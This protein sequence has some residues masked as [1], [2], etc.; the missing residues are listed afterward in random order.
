MPPI[1]PIQFSALKTLNP[2]HDEVEHGKHHDRQADVRQVE[3]GA[4]LGLLRLMSLVASEPRWAGERPGPCAT[5]AGP[6]QSL[7]RSM[8]PRRAGT[9][10]MAA[11]GG[12]PGRPSPGCWPGKER[13]TCRAL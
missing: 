7:T 13:S 11:S 10:D 6:R 4:L 1:R 5:H 9:P 2:L 3:H 12:R 8:R